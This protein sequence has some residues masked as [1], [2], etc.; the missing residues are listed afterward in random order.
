MSMFFMFLQSKSAVKGFPGRRVSRLDP[1]FLKCFCYSFFLHRCIHRCSCSFGKAS[2]VWI[3][4]VPAHRVTWVISLALSSLWKI[5][6]FVFQ[7]CV[8]FMPSHREKK[9]FPGPGLQILQEHICT[10]LHAWSL[11]TTIYNRFPLFPNGMRA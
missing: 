5:E 1:C 6:L 8:L 7:S 3:V 10:L 11:F 4:D 2:A 9:K